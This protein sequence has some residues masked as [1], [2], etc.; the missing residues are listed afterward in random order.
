MHRMLFM[1]GQIDGIILEPTDLG[2]KKWFKCLYSK[3]IQVEKKKKKKKKEIQKKLQ[4]FL[5]LW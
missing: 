3:E 5:I 4:Q 1:S 2:W